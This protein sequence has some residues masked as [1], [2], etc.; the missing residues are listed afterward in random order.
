MSSTLISKNLYNNLQQQTTTLNDNTELEKD[1]ISYK[2][3]GDF[4]QVVQKDISKSIRQATPVTDVTFD[5]YGPDKTVRQ[6]T[7]KG[8]PIVL[9][10]SY[11]NQYPI[12]EISNA[13]LDAVNAA[14]SAVGINLN[15]LGNQ[16]SVSTSDLANI[17]NAISNALP[18]AQIITYTYDPLIGVTTITDARGKTSYY[19]YDTLGR[20]KLIRDQDNNVLKTFDYQYQVQP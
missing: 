9:L 19:E 20:L 2:V 13:E 16:T 7:Q 15:N 12:A 17:R 14:L 5:K 11:K 3:E 10:W 4:G 6:F 8:L 18:K 1:I